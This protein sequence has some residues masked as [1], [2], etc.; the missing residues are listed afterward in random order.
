[1]FL[2]IS[3]YELV[4]AQIKHAIFKQQKIHINLKN[5][6]LTRTYISHFKMGIQCY[7]PKKK[8]I[9]L[10]TTYNGFSFYCLTM[11]P[12]PLITQG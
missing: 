5:Q 7:F 10:S 2:V 4:H 11:C 1:M 3:Y 12:P 6:C 8:I 9:S